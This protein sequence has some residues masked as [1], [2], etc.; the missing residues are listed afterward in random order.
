VNLYNIS[1][2]QFLTFKMGELTSNAEYITLVRDN[3]SGNQGE[4]TGSSLLKQDKKINFP[5]N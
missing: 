1:E 5:S 2:F 4:S 3:K